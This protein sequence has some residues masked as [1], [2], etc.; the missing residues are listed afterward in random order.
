MTPAAKPPLPRLTRPREGRM[1][2]GVAQ[3]L[4]EH[5]RLEPWH[6]RIGLLVLCL[7]SGFGLLL[8]VVLWVLVRDVPDRDARRGLPGIGRI[9]VAVAAGAIVAG[10]AG[11]L[12]SAGALSQDRFAIPIALAL[13]GAALMWRQADDAQRARWARRTGELPARLVGDRRGIAAIRIA[14]GLILVGGGVA[15]FLA[16]SHQL[17]AA[18]N[19]VAATAVVLLGLAVLTGPLWWRLVSELSAERQE[20][21]RSQERAE[22]AAHL[23]DSVLQTLALIQREADSPREVTRLARGQER[24]LRTWLYRPQDAGRTRFAPALEAAAGDVEDA[25]GIKVEAIVVG[26][27]ELDSG[28]EALVQ[29]SREAVVNAA[30]HAGVQEI[31]LYAELEEDA[32]TVFVRDRGRGFD[33]DAVPEDRHGLAGSIIGRMERHGGTATITSRPGAGT[34]VELRMR[35]AA[36]EKA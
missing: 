26:D 1:I 8:Y 36:E 28:L 7:F 23:H 14:G 6:V 16:L 17:S 31:S 5:L 11:L 2:A 25:Y 35:R 20:R 24:E 15:L 3:G 13:L 34:E 18:R 32:V 29:A 9:A 4:A 12:H 33:P 10:G 21:I 27:A 30:K 19:G 22:L